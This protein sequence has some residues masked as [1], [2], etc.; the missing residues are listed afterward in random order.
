MFPERVPIVTYFR[1]LVKP[2]SGGAT[3]ASRHGKSGGT[4]GRAGRA[5]VDRVGASRKGA[6]AGFHTQ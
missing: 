5:W 3:A 1:F 4:E 6:G 2:P